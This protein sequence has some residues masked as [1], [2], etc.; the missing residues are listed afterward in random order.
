MSHKILV[1][2]G[3]T[4]R[5]LDVLRSEGFEVDVQKAMPPEELVKIVAPYDA[6]TVRS[7]SKITADVIA[8]AA[9]LKVVGRPG[10]GVDNIDL[11]AAT[12]R[13]VIVMNAPLGNMV[14][15]A[16]LALALLLAV[17]RNIAQ[18]DASMKKGTWDRK[19]FAGVELCGKRI[20]VIGLG[21]IG[22]EMGVRCKALG[23]DVVGYDPFVSQPLVEGLGI[24][25]LSLD[26][27]FA[28]SDFL[29]LHSVLSPE[30]RQ[31]INKDTI[32]KMKPGVRIVNA[33]RGALIDEAALFEALE[34]GRVAGAGL[35][36]HA[37]EPP[38]DWKLA[39]HPNVVAM[40]HVGAS[41]AEAQEKVGTDIAIQI[42]D[43]LKGGI[44]QQA[45]NFFQLSSDI[46]EHVKPAMD[47]AERLGAFVGQALPGKPER[48]EIGLY[49][50]FR[51]L[52][53]KPI[54]PAAVAG[55]LRG[56]ATGVTVVNAL[57][58]AKERGLQIVESTSSAQ[59]SFANL[60]A[61]RYKTSEAELSVSGTYFGPGQPRLVD[62]DGV[63]VD[64]IP[65]GHVL[66]VKND[67]TPGVIGHI[68][69]T[70]GGRRIN[71]AR[72]TV[73][74]KPGSA[75]AVMMIE[76]DGEVTLETLEALRRIAG[77]KEAKAIRLG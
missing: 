7:S 49:G 77:V 22:R 68:G 15:T 74:R 9:N 3:M 5:G 14:S 75:R 55:V 41:T 62:V 36:V 29:T 8:A 16:E 26:E 35:D 42:R 61:V 2:E 47:L 64:A 19:S 1:L 27:L 6:I 69:S 39:Q 73:G 51:D 17:A 23:M 32:A 53:L 52:D 44:I 76:V 71:I 12:R 33:A 24:T 66:Y 21:R 13:G 28:T 50:D 34:S 54:L 60:V 30:T 4:E 45:V 20:G 48:L 10:V 11:E 31:L 65:A 63:E 72:M 58:A 67:D 59:L 38:V 37:K 18:G 25:L 43:Y 46:Y 40:P 57:Q 70:L 56:S